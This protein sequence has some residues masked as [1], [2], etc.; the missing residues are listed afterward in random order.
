MGSGKLE[1]KSTL[2]WDVREKKNNPQLI[3]SSLKTIASFLNTEG[4]VLLIGVEDNGNIYGI[5]KDVQLTKNKSHDSLE[6]QFATTRLA[7]MREIYMCR[8]C[9]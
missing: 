8:Q 7:R 4:G 9:P 5:E 6:L 3:N 2:E 1:F